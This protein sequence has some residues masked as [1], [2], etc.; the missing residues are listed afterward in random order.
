M[1][2]VTLNVPGISCEHCERTIVNTL[3][4]EP[5]VESV[6]V[7]VPSRKV[8]LSYD[9]KSLSLDHVKELLDEEGYTV[10]GVTE[11]TAPDGK[12][13]FIPLSGK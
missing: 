12:R 8:Y 2:S 7:N 9:D 1:S 11:G 4:D 3:K 13:N 6:Q 5:G 10:E